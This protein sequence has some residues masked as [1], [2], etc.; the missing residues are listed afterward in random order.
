MEFSIN[1]DTAVS[2]LLQYIDL[3]EA[4]NS[5]RSDSMASAANQ[6]RRLVFAISQPEE[7]SDYCPEALVFEKN[8]KGY[9]KKLSKQ[10]KDGASAL[11]LNFKRYDFSE[12]VPGYGWYEPQVNVA[13]LTYR[14]S[15]LT[16]TAT[17]GFNDPEGTL[18][19]IGLRGHAANPEQMSEG[20]IHFSLDNAAVPFVVI[21]DKARVYVWIKVPSHCVMHELAI[22]MKERIVPAETGAGK[23]T[24]K[25][26]FSVVEI[27]EAHAAA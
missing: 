22:H 6:M 1:K 10:A 2:Q 19:W 14:W 4:E 12:E 16:E 7:Q 27:I 25:L 18:R 15:G 21:P 20:N 13:K 5:E 17:I 24:R 23:D 8:A 26:G 9:A 3:L 11:G